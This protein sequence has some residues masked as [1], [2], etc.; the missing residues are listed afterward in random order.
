MTPQQMLLHMSNKSI[1]PFGA[2]GIIG[3]AKLG[4]VTLGVLLI[5]GIYWFLKDAHKTLQEYTT[6]SLNN[7]DWNY[8]DD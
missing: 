5:G 8:W 2:A 4:S 1:N 3:L 6:I 7:D